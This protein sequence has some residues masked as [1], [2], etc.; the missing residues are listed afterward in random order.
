MGLGWESNQLACIAR[1][2]GVEKRDIEEKMKQK[3]VILGEMS[4]HNVYDV[5]EM[6]SYYYS[7]Q[8]SL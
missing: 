2:T 5:A 8:N 6:I 7:N 3:A 1:R 4:K